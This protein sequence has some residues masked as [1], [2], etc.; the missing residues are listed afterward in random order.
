MVA[1]SPAF[2]WRVKT[3]MVALLSVPVLV[4]RV[5]FSV[6]LCYTAQTVPSRSARKNAAGRKAH[7]KKPWKRPGLI[8]EAGP[9]SVRPVRAS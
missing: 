1:L 3:S 5:S 7:G 9:H 2:N 6:A 8:P 4:S